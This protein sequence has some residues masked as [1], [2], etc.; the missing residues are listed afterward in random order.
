MEWWAILIIV[1]TCSA[2]LIA[3]QMSR[4]ITRRLRRLEPPGTYT[5]KMS[6]LTSRLLEASR[7]VDEVLTE[8][9]DAHRRQEAILR[10]QDERVETLSANEKELQ[11]RVK[12]LKELPLPVAEYFDELSRKA[13]EEQDKKRAWRDYKLIII[14]ALLSAAITAAIM[15]FWG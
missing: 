1:Y 2:L 11:Q 8:M 9:A 13:Q 12:S 3:V 6:E 5:E 15:A 4:H 7:A 10:Q 14:S